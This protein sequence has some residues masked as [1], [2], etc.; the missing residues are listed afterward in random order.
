MPA[1]V[2]LMPNGELPLSTEMT[3]LGMKK[4]H[5]ALPTEM[6]PKTHQKPKDL[7][8]NRSFAPVLVQRW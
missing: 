1:G 2:F 3:P 6:T 8:G 4:L 7:L 5:R